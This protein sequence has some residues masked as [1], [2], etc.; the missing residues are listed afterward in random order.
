MRKSIFLS[1]S[2]DD[3]DEEWG[4]RRVVKI[5]GFNNLDETAELEEKIFKELNLLNES[6]QCLINK[7]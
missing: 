4:L 5:Y 1:H 3:N 7:E 6:R 2:L